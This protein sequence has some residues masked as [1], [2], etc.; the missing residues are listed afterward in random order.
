MDTNSEAFKSGVRNL[1]LKLKMETHP[2]STV[3]LEA[4][5][6]I[7]HNRLRPDVQH[8]PIPTGTAFPIQSGGQCAY[9]DK[10]MEQAAK[11]LRLLQI[12]V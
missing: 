2:D 4:A 7:I 5:S 3:S 6:R 9:D 1:A 8:I 10:N 12:Q 11:I